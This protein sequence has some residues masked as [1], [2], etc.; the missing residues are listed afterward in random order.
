MGRLQEAIAARSSRM[1][2]EVVTRR[3]AVEERVLPVF[4]DDRLPNDRA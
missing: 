1:P 4:G 2:R 3:R